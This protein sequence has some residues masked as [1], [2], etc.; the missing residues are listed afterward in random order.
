LIT[1]PAHQLAGARLFF[2]EQRPVV[3]EGIAIEELEAGPDR[4]EG[5]S[6]DAQLIA[7]VEEEILDLP[8]G[9]LIGGDHVSGGQL[10]NGAEILALSTPD[11]SGELQVADHACSEFG[12]RDTLS[13]MESENPGHTGRKLKGI[14]PH[15]RGHQPPAAC[16]PTTDRFPHPAAK[17]LRP[18][19][20]ENV[21]PYQTRT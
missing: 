9:E 4:S 6:G 21:N 12:H 2:R 18:S 15:I 8:L 1:G 3:A 20:I 7:D 10:A 11:Q 19:Q 17:P 16:K 5:P 13:C 14:R